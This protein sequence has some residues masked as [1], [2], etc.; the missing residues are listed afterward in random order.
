METPRTGTF[1][2]HV[3]VGHDALRLLG[4]FTQLAAGFTAWQAHA[5]QTEMPAP[6]RQTKMWAAAAA[7]ERDSRRAQLGQQH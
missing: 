4:G 7:A 3:Q 6:L 1:G 2:L 5:Q